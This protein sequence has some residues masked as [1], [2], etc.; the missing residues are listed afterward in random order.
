MNK[1]YKKLLKKILLCS[2]ALAQASVYAEPSLSVKERMALFEEKKSQAE[3]EKSSVPLRGMIKPN[4]SAVFR[5]KQAI[6]ELEKAL[7][8]MDFETIKKII[9]ANQSIVNS[10]QAEPLRATVLKVCYNQNDRNKQLEI[11]DYLLSVNGINVNLLSSKPVAQN[12]LDV[13]VKNIKGLKGENLKAHY[14]VIAQKL[15]A[16]GAVLSELA[17]VDDAREIVAQ[18][19]N[20]KP[21]VAE[22]QEPVVSSGVIP[23]ISVGASDSVSGA[24]QE[25]MPIQQAGVRRISEV[26][27]AGRMI[28]PIDESSDSLGM[29]SRVEQN[30][31]GAA[32][33]DSRSEL[34]QA[35][36]GVADRY[37]QPEEAEQESSV[38]L[39]DN[40]DEDEE[41]VVS[42]EGASE[43]S[44]GS[45]TSED[46]ERA[47]LSNKIAEYT[48]ELTQIDDEL[49]ALRSKK[50]EQENELNKITQDVDK[51][52]RKI[53]DLHKERQE[54]TNKLSSK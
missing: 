6:T 15:I 20:V 24:L 12:A 44:E 3:Q 9:N 45:I 13:A 54:L 50:S 4:M 52:E 40:Q 41:V 18:L 1:N 26:S 19:S 7:Q 38:F 37:G 33:V 8:G 53:N 32:G 36:A 22:A 29:R 10:Q 27:P 25:Q 17:G 34:S 2:L 16:Q 31:P 42:P 43:I 21:A 11:L 39:D 49:R 30:I 23:Q 51:Q 14:R 5:E 47:E 35:Q 48:Q 46:R 28:R